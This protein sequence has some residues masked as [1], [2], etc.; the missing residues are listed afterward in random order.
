MRRHSVE[1]S[2]GLRLSKCSFNNIVQYILYHILLISFGKLLLDSC[3]R[4]QHYYRVSVFCPLTSQHEAMRNR[5]SNHWPRGALTTGLPAQ[6]HAQN[7]VFYKRS[8]TTCFYWFLIN[9][10]VICE[11][12]LIWVPRIKLY[13]PPLYLVRSKNLWTNKTNINID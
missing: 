7:M 11:W 10:F 12:N 5:E 9:V 13:S 3:S 1:I 8:E 6:L 2:Q 4:W